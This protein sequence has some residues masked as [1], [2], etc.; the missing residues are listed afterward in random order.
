MAFENP[1]IVDFVLKIVWLWDFTGI[2][3]GI[4][5]EDALESR[6]ILDQ[7]QALTST[8]EPKTTG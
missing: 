5:R 3:S 1:L 2:D 6:T 4:H 8:A 7:C